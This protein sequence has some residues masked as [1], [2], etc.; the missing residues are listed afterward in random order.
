MIIELESKA[1]LQIRQAG[2]EYIEIADL[3]EDGIGRRIQYTKK[4]WQQNYFR[5]LNWLEEEYKLTE[6]EKWMIGKLLDGLWQD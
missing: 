6:D 3:L 5:E 4:Y 1:R 2:V